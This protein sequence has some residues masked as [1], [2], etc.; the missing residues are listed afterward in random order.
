MNLKKIIALALVLTMCL[1][2]IPTYAFADD[3]IIIEDGFDVIEEAEEIAEIEEPEEILVEAAEEP[4]EEVADP[5]DDGVVAATASDENTEEA[6]E[7]QQADEARA[8]SISDTAAFN[9]GGTVHNAAEL[10]A[11]LE[12][13]TV[14][15]GTIVDLINDAEVSDTIVLDLGT[16]SIDLSLYGYSLSNPNGTV[17]WLKSG[18]LFTGYGTFESGD[19]EVPVIRV[20]EG[21]TLVIYY[22]L[23]CNGGDPGISVDGPNANVYA[24]VDAWGDPF[25]KGS[26]TSGYEWEKSTYT[27]EGDTCQQL[28]KPMCAQIGDTKYETL[29]DAVENAAAG[30]IIVLLADTTEGD[31]EIRKDL[32]VD[33]NGHTLTIDEDADAAFNV[34]KKNVTFTLK[35]SADGGK[36]VSDSSSVY[37]VEMTGNG[38]AFVMDGGSIEL[39]GA[40]SSGVDVTRTGT[41]TINGGSIDVTAKAI[42]NNSDAVINI[43]G[44]TLKGNIAVYN[45]SGNVNISGGT[46]NGTTYAVQMADGGAT[47]ISGSPALTGALYANAAELISITGGTYSLDPST[48]VAEGKI[49]WPTDDGFEILAAVTVTFDADGGKLEGESSFQLAEGKSLNDAATVKGYTY[50]TTT[51]TGYGFNGWYDGE[52]ELD[53]DAAVAANVTYKAQWTDAVARIDTNYYAS[54]AEAVAAAEP[55]QT[56]VLMRNA[57]ITEPVVVDKTITI[58]LNAN[59][60]TNNGTGYA[61]NITAGNVQIQKGTIAGSGKGITATGSSTVVSLGSESVPSYTLA[62]DVAGCALDLHDGATAALVAGS[63]LKTSAAG[64]AAVFADA[65]TTF[66]MNGGTVSG[67]MTI[68]NGKTKFITGG[69]FSEIPE[70][71][72][73]VDGKACTSEKNA[74]GYYEVVDAVTVTFNANE[75]TGEMAA[76]KI[77]KS[78]PTE[79]SENTFTRTGYAFNGWN[80]AADG[81]GT[82][83][84]DKAEVTLTQDITLYAQWTEYVTIETTLDMRDFIGI[85]VYIANNK[86]DASFDDYTITASYKGETILNNEPVSEGGAR[87]RGGVDTRWFYVAKVDSI[88]MAEPVEVK[89]FYQGKPVTEFTTSVQDYCEEKIP[90][91]SGPQRDLLIGLLDFGRYAQKHFSGLVGTLM[92]SEPTA[93]EAVINATAIP[94]Y[95]V[96]IENNEKS[97]I[98]GGSIALVLN[99]ATAM[100]VYFAPT[101]AN[102][103]ISNYR[104]YV[105]GVRVGGTAVDGQFLVT[106]DDIR[107]NELFGTHT[108]TAYNRATKQSFSLTAAPA[109][110]LYQVRDTEGTLSPLAKAMYRFGDAAVNAFSN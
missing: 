105:D 64:E 21:A 79:L 2:L 45:L 6:A 108:V 11:L 5:V 80:T 92:H 35:D 47:K 32:T 82:A 48:Y 87:T 16:D 39:T 74:E 59:T 18:T 70:A 76:Q 43:A 78:S 14:G 85:R 110:Y 15:D 38:A 77:G 42:A 27:Y 104:F 4:T 100:N 25:Y 90:T 22:D 57:E 9:V 96:T 62:V 72:W 23:Y 67:T 73:I 52:T 40:N 94:E 44:G 13:D 83:Y 19:G 95:T 7:E 63:A 56:V 51:K 69:Y 28:V 17:L 97:G 46:L 98:S 102:A 106:V 3:E 54:L 101:D 29:A 68:N 60:L 89:L 84:A 103:K 75:G 37:A 50:P 107:S 81:S 71:D 8:L 33:L 86:A 55:Y 20:S 66:N 99:A 30:D 31:I 109:A 53:L 41:V 36:I 10:H 65:N 61:L 91:L 26:V 58:D 34:S 12:D 24:A 93:G 49:S 1:S 88:D